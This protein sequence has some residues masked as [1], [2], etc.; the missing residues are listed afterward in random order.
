MTVYVD[1]FRVFA[2]LREDAAAYQFSRANQNCEK[3]HSRI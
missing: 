1:E 3:A 2:P